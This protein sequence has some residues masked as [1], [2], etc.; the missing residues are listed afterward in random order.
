MLDRAVAHT[1]TFVTVAPGC[2]I[3]LHRSQHVSTFD[4]RTS[5][6]GRMTRE[7]STYT[8]TC[9]GRC[10]ES[11]VWARASSS[12]WRRSLVSLRRRAV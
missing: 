10:R 5:R 8:Y 9:S 2:H 6:E 3:G 1:L 12:C 11:R 4:R 7:S